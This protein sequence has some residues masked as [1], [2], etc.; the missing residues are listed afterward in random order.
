MDSLNVSTPEQT[1]TVPDGSE[2]QTGAW[3]RIR[4]IMVLTSSKC[5]RVR[6]AKIRERLRVYRGA[7]R[8]LIKRMPDEDP[9]FF[10]LKPKLTPPL[11]KHALRQISFAYDI[12]PRR[13]LEDEEAA[14]DWDRLFWSRGGSGWDSDAASALPLTK[15]CGDLIAWYQWSDGDEDDPKPGIRTRLVTPDKAVVLS[16]P[17]TD[18]MHAVIML[19]GIAPAKTAAPGLSDSHHKVE[20]WHYL[21]RHYYARIARP[22]NHTAS[23]EVIPT[24]VPGEE[25]QTKHLIPHGFSRI[26]AQALPWTYDPDKEGFW[27][28]PWGGDDLI[29][30][31]RAIY[32]ASSEYVWT[33]MLQRGQPVGRKITHMPLGPHYMVELGDDPDS[34][35]NIIPNNANLGGFR[36]CVRLMLDLSAKTWGL[37]SRT[38]RLE[39]VAAMSGIAIALDRGELE[40]QRRSDEQTWRRNEYGAA[41][42]VQ[43]IIEVRAGIRLPLPET[44]TYAPLAPILTP[45]QRHAQVTIERQEGTMSLREMKA[46]LHPDYAP[47]TITQLLEAAGAGSGVV[48]PEDEAIIGGAGGG[49]E[50]QK[51]ALNGA[52]VA[53]LQEMLLA[54][55]AGTL[56][57]GAA[58][59]AIL[60]AF[61]TIEPAAAQEMV[62]ASAAVTPPPEE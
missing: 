54:V 58:E 43:E 6:R 13:L 26:P 53:A 18:T 28:N 41:V 46:E 57:P 30:T 9:R 51:Q 62:R 55:T 27:T 11:L 16:D 22:R 50:I 29:P 39:D 20:I 56:A 24:P 60:A 23:F 34:F 3:G 45:E 4:D 33:S 12:P 48:D 32:S 59:L 5:D 37:P 15:L 40:D 36:D 14:K 7:A 10:A 2:D 35:F 42:I 31:L 19:A 25:G 1:L 17:V 21:D 52:Q 38:F 47:E 49:E 44:V 61:P 8:H